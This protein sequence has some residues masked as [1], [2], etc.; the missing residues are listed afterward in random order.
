VKA[1]LRNTPLASFP[2]HG[3]TGSAL[4]AIARVARLVERGR[5]VCESDDLELDFAAAH[6]DVV[7]TWSVVADATMVRALQRRVESGGSLHPL[8][9]GRLREVNARAHGALAD[10][11][12]GLAA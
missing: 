11:D 6:F 10:L 9:R 5:P 2:D 12:R 7:G 3:E 8:D 4:L 1:I